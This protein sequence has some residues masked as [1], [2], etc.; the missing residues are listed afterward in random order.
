MVQFFIICQG[1]IIKR[2][3]SG[4]VEGGSRGHEI[5]LILNPLPT[6]ENLSTK[7]KKGEGREASRVLTVFRI[8]AFEVL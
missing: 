8:L 5:F 2:S 6:Q 1:Y 4:T 3:K 7:K